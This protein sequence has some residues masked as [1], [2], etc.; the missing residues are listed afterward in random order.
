M[1]SNESGKKYYFFSSNEK[2]TF[3]TVKFSSQSLIFQVDQSV[4]WQ[5]SERFCGFRSCPIKKC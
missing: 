1:N 3:F 5:F 4:F 2:V